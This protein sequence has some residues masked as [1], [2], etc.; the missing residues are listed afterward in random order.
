M[1]SEL[2]WEILTLGW[3]DGSMVRAPLVLAEDLGSISDIHT[4][5]H[6]HLSVI[7]VPGNPMPLSGL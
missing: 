6:S 2:S 5:T 4:V 7:L 3:R 1:S